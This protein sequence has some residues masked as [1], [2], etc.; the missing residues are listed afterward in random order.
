M[1]ATANAH[2]KYARIDRHHQLADIWHR[3]LEAYGGKSANFYI[4]MPPALIQ[5]ITRRPWGRNHALH[6][7]RRDLVFSDTTRCLDNR[8]E[9][10]HGIELLCVV[11]NNRAAASRSIKQRQKYNG[12]NIS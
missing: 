8:R 10:I 4:S 7:G 6:E 12:A 2:H 11:T 3:L 1:R 9:P 5:N